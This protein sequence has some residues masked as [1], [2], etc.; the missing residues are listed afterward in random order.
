MQ[1]S[2][3]ASDTTA[4]VHEGLL[5]DLRIGFL[6]EEDLLQND[7]SCGCEPIHFSQLRYPVNKASKTCQ[8]CRCEEQKKTWG[9]IIVYSKH[10][11]RWCTVVRPKLS[12]C[13][14][15]L[16]KSDGTPVDDWKQLCGRTV[17]TAGKSF[18]RLTYQGNY[19]QQQC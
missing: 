2:E 4:N 13:G 7:S 15:Q 1:A 10:A 8:V 19:L 14:P 3:D 16:M 11:I 12:A 17:Y 9:S 6:T 18:I 5:A